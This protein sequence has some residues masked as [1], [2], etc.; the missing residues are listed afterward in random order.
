MADY[1]FKSHLDICI[2]NFINQ[3]HSLGYPYQSSARL[4]Y[5]FDLFVAENFGPMTPEEFEQMCRAA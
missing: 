1:V 3:K 4:L 5:H 2:K